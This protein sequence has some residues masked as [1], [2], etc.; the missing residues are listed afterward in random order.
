[1]GVCTH[2]ICCG[3]S[4]V[5]KSANGVDIDI[6]NSP[7]FIRF[8]DTS[9]ACMKNLKATGQFT[10]QQAEIITE[11]IEDILWNKGLLGDSNLQCLFDTFV[12]YLRLFVL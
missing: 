12:F 5:L 10:V 8:R 9:D 7:K 4:R 2:Q 6:F 3:Q 11:E 1:M